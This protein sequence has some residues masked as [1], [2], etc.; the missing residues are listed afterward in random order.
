MPRLNPLGRRLEPFAISNITLHLVIAQTF[1]YLATMFGYVDPLR[2]VLVPTLVMHGEPW[3]LITFLFMP[4]PSHWAL[5]AFALYFIYFSGTA[6]EQHWGTLRYNLFLL[7][8]YLLT[9]GGAFVAPNFISTNVYIGAAIFLAFAYTHPDVE[10]LLLFIIP[11]KMKWLGLFE[12]AVLFFQLVRGDIAT[13]LG[14][15]AA[16]AS[17][18]GFIARDLSSDVRSGRRRMKLQATRAAQEA[19]EREPRHRCYVCGK[20]D[21]TNPEMDF[22]Y[23]S[24]CVGDQCYCPEHIRNH[25]H[26]LTETK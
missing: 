24:K 8:C 19:A 14:I 25:V 16:V 23:C 6:L 12:C 10:A 3:R 20:T 2:W 17:V 4:P 9:V 5:I 11:A 22:R 13:R 18:L 15:I 1:V 7:T 21:Q 26:V